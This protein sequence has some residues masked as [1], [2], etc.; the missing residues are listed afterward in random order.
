MIRLRRGVQER[1]DLECQVEL[2]R[3]S[4][5]T[6]WVPSQE[7]QDCLELRVKKT[8]LRKRNGPGKARI[9][10]SKTIRSV[11][12]KTEIEIK[13]EVEYNMYSATKLAVLEVQRHL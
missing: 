12:L 7:Q 5:E 11:E 2:A 9:Q 13:E 3:M 8:S 6:R 10:V 1:H 4:C